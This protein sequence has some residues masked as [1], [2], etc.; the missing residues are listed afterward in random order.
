MQDGIVIWVVYRGQREN[1]HFKDLDKT[2]RET[3][4]K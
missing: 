1:I 3:C 2:L 4:V